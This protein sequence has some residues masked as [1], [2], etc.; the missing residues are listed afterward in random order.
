MTYFHSIAPTRAEVD[1]KAPSANPTFSGAVAVPV[2]TTAAPG[3][4]P[5]DDPDTGIT[6]TGPDTLVLAT[7][8]VARVQIDAA[9]A[10]GIGG[11]PVE[12][13]HLRTSGPD[14]MRFSRPGHDDHSIN[15]AG[16]QGLQIRNTTDARTE[17][18]MSGDG[19][20]ALSGLLGSEALRTTVTANAV[21]RIGVSGATTAGAP[22]LSA[23]GSDAAIDLLL[24]PKGNG[25]VRL[26][27]FAAGGD[28]PVVGYIEIKDSAGVPR[29]LAVIA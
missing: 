25:R 21:N 24:Q 19:S 7:G 10:I 13:L 12:P 15:L 1:A 27:T 8:G 2:G 14:G 18:V 3:L 5:A 20:V 11:A 29:K 26:G 16:G 9:G 28:A 6:Q 17:I 22:S 23:Q 4:H